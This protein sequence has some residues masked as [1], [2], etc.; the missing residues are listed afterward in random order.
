MMMLALH[1]QN[2]PI[3]VFDHRAKVGQQ[4]VTFYHSRII[5]LD[6]GF[7]HLKLKRDLDILL[8]NASDPFGGDRLLPLGNLRE[9]VSGLKRAGLVVLTHVDRVSEEVLAA[10]R[11]RIQKVNPRAH[12][13]ESVHRPDFLLDVRSEKRLPLAH[14]RGRKVVSLSGIADPK[15]FE[16][17]LVENEISLAQ[18]WRYPDHHPYRLRELRALNRLGPELPIVTTFK[19]FTRLPKGWQEAL[20]GELYVLAIKLDIIK[21]RNH[22]IDS[23]I[24][25]AS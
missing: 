9:P 10:L 6:D 19:D 18:R 1:G 16:E 3:V 25:L 8:V 2:V 21:G 11:A 17:M 20:P 7:Q 13:L 15:Q 5:I 14:L 12:L 22:W 23:L 24:Q 4:A